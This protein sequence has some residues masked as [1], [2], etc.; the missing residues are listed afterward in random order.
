VELPGHQVAYQAVHVAPPAVQRHPADA[1]ATRH[2]HESRAS[3]ADGEDTGAYSVEHSLV[4]V[5]TAASPGLDV[6]LCC[7]L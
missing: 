1:G 2:V 4:A 6:T 5:T 3:D 7:H